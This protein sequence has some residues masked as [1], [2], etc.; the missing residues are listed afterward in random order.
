MSGE[1]WGRWR[2]VEVCVIVIPLRVIESSGGGWACVLGRGGSGAL[3][4]GRSICV[5]GSC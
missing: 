5:G 4:R 2:L 3:G 1:G